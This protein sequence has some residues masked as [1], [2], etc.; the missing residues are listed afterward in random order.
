MF[1]EMVDRLTP[2]ISKQDIYYSKA[3]DPGLKVAIT[4]CYMATWDSSKRLQ[5]GFRVAYN[6]I[7][8]LTADV[9]AAI[10][11]AYHDEVIITPTTPDD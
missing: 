3:L 7:C 9:S 2:L 6:T 8:L 5:Y 1:Q 11:D 4:L 10:V